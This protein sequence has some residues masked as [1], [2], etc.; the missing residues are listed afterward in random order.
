VPSWYL[1]MSFCHSKSWKN[2]FIVNALVCI[3]HPLLVLTQC[4]CHHCFYSY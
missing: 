1:I 2:E 4:I 3:P